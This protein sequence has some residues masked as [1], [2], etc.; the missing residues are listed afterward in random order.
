MEQEKIRGLVWNK[1][2]FDARWE[3]GKKAKLD[4]DWWS[5]NVGSGQRR[6]WIETPAMDLT[7][8]MSEYGWG[9]VFHNEKTNGKWSKEEKQLHIHILEMKAVL[10]GLMSFCRELENIQIKCEIDNT[11]AFAYINHKGGTKSVACDEVAREIWGFAEE[12]R[13]WLLAIHLPG[14]ENVEADHESSLNQADFEEFVGFL[15]LI[16]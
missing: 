3:L 15:T 10:F 13:L 12:R 1:G 4:L 6:I 2:D 9:A 14:V 11:T 8:D 7:T 5:Q 16:C